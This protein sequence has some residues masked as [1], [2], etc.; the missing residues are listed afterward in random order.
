MWTGPL[1]FF[2]GV[3]AGPPRTAEHGRG[4]PRAVTPVCP[5]MNDHALKVL[6]YDKVRD[7]VARFA[8]SD[9]GRDAV[10]RLFP[11]RTAARSRA[12]RGDAGVPRDPACGRTPAAGQYQRHR[13]VAREA[14]RRGHAA[15]ARGAARHRGDAGRVPQAQGVLPALDGSAAAP[16]LCGRAA[17]IT[18]LKE[19]EDS[20]HAAIDETGEVR[21]SASPS[22]AGSGSSSGGRGTASWTGWCASSGARTRRAWSRNS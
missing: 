12:A 13:S 21:D 15:A 19:L 16:L 4:A 2:S 1:L 17:S 10:L 5:I 20:V 3:A 11:R 18:P 7:I 9:P 6:E 8:A 14:P 22:S